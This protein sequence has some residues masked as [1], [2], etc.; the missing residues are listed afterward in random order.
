MKK[1]MKRTIGRCFFLLALSL[2]LSSCV[3]LNTLRQLQVGTPRVSGVRLPSFGSRELGVNLLVK[4]ENPA[5]YVKISD[6]SGVVRSGQT[7]VGSFTAADLAL[8][9]RSG[10]DYPVDI[11]LV[12]DSGLSV[13]TLLSLVKSFNPSDYVCDLSFRLSAN[14]NAKG[15]SVTLKDQPLSK[16]FKP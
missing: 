14:P 5:A 15:P 1:K 16:F 6:I 11:R 12:P 10:K 4:V 8:D 7:V 13:L 9:A 3:G 2:A